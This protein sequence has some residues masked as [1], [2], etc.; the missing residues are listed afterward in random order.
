MAGGARVGKSGD[1]CV[2]NAKGLGLRGGAEG[3]GGDLVL[4]L[5]HALAGRGPGSVAGVVGD[6]RLG[7]VPADLGAQLIDAGTHGEDAEDGLGGGDL[8]DG[9]GPD[10]LRQVEL[11]ADVVALAGGGHQREA[12]QGAAVDVELLLELGAEDSP[13]G[14]PGTVVAVADADELEPVIRLVGYDA[15]GAAI[16]LGIVHTHRFLPL[17][18]PLDCVGARQLKLR[19][20]S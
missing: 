7:H 10:E 18:V 12:G 2:R 8:L 3:A 14:E 15:E 20:G 16:P 4:G 6:L 5:P 19:R 17:L 11:G 13:L 1:P 9:G